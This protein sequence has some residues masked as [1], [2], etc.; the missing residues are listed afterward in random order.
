VL[1]KE[2]LLGAK[3]ISKSTSKYGDVLIVS[4][5]KQWAPK[6]ECISVGGPWRYIIFKK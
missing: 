6:D 2:H 1:Y 4:A 5:E 3:W